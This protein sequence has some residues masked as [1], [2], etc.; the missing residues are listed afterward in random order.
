MRCFF[1]FLC[2]MCCWVGSVSAKPSLGYV[3]AVYGGWGIKE[4]FAMFAMAFEK[5]KSDVIY[6]L[7][8][9][10]LELSNLDLRAV[11]AF[12]DQRDVL[13]DFI[14]SHSFNAGRHS[15]LLVNFFRLSAKVAH[16][17]QPDD[18]VVLEFKRIVYQNQSVTRI[19][20]ETE[21]LY[22]HVYEI[23]S[24]HVDWEAF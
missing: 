16:W 2:A 19:L 15:D 23:V 9:E 17:Y 11:S 14:K 7:E 8:S 18:P 20:S 6:F 22:R 24:A 5:T 21:K 10:N 3:R 1:S 4:G 12:L 13:R